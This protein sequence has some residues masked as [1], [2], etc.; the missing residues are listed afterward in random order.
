MTKPADE[1]EQRLSGQPLRRGGFTPELKNR[2]RERIRMRASKTKLAVRAAAVMLCAALISMG[3]L[4]REDMKQLAMG[5]HQPAYLSA[6]TEN[7][8]ADEGEIRLKVQGTATSNFMMNY[9][10]AF[11]IRH[12]NVQF[13]VVQAG[14]STSFPT[15]EQFVEWMEREQPDVMSLPLDLFTE[16]AREGKLQPLDASI[17]KDGFDL[18]AFHKPVIQLLREA[19]A[20]ELYGLAPE[21]SSMAVYVNKELFAKYE[22]PLPQDGMSWEELLETAKRFGG[23]GDEVA[24]L[25]S[26]YSNAP[27]FLIQMIGEAKG[28]RTVSA[29]GKTVTF[30]TPSWRT[31]WDEVSQGIKQGWIDYREPL[32]TN[33]NTPFEDVLEEDPFINGKAAMY[34][35]G[36]YFMA[37][38]RYAESNMKADLDWM[39]V[40]EPVDPVYSVRGTSFAVPTV[41]AIRADSPNT[42]VAWEVLKHLASKE[43]GQK[44]ARKSGFYSPLTSRLGVLPKA[45]EEQWRGF[46]QISPD[47]AILLDVA[48]SRP[49]NSRSIQR[50]DLITEAVTAVISGEQ[51]VD[52]ALS[53]LQQEVEKELAQASEGEQ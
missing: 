47:P 43:I 26:A 36:N 32:D 10:K 6:V 12:P 14:S 50:Y 13:D 5:K 11:V 35:G 44:L 1:W 17:K 18:E 22:V 25:A 7:Q 42:K 46:Y 48:V 51:T 24:G 20:G 8:L 49:E 53:R 4:Y 37:R 19:G 33:G 2:V 40:S 15:K 30:D 16:L 29:D 31:V 27:Y 9:G 38:L 3:W 28:L 41:F 34:L 39:T 21:F 23:R 52:E 45:D